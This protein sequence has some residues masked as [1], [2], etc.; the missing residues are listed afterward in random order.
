MP[1][2]KKKAVEILLPP[3]VGYSFHILLNFLKKNRVS[4]RYYGRLLAMSVINI[5]NFPFRTYE[6]LLINPRIDRSKI[7]EPPIFIIGHWRSGT[8]HLHN[9]LTQDKQM[10]YLTTYQGVF[11][12]TMF[13]YLG[14]F[15][16][17]N[18]TKVLIPRTRKGDNVT[19][20]TDNPQE[21]EF[22]L[23]DK[24]RLSYY[25]FWMF[26]E[27]TLD[28]YEEALRTKDVPEKKLSKWKHE[29]RLLVKKALKNTGR[30]IF[31]SKNPPSTARIKT[32][33]DTFPEAR[34]IH[35][36]RNPVEVYLSTNHFFNIMM[37]HLQLQTT[38]DPQREE[39]ILEVY[40]KMMH[41]YLE[42]K[43]LIPA[44]RLVEIA[45]DKL[46]TDP[47]GVLDYVYHELNLPGFEE[48]K[49]AFKSYVQSM[50]S[51]RKNRHSISQEKLDKVLS[52]WGFAM[53]HW[54]YEVPDSIDITE[55]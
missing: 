13:N 43:A 10:G 19:L 21:E 15:I 30:P 41:H 18:F 31:L 42:D 23:G 51:Y 28:Y 1:N 44:D 32:L 39:L 4:P 27:N 5:I 6:R 49:P 16:F 20:K 26:P 38:S 3:A 29:Y 47:L 52:Q 25:Y 11:P 50:K 24:T 40:Q 46:E 2:P 48:A 37:P 12:D 17:K 36:H 45:F 53:N 34:F 55:S 54:N 8:T 7:T 22:A 35:I 9:L 33:L 14:K